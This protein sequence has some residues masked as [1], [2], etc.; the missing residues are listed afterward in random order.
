M[1]ATILKSSKAVDTTIA[2]VEVYAKLRELSR[3]MVELPQQE[4]GT[5]IQKELLHRGGQL[6]DDLV[7]DV[8]PKQS[9]ETS[10]ELNLAMFKFRHSVRRG[11]DGGKD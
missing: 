8:L 5:V 3:V 11:K 6:I 2:I 10:F 1:L 7:T 9:T 4:E